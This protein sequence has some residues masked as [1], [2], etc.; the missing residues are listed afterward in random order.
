MAVTWQGDSARNA[1][2]WILG[3]SRCGSAQNEHC[4][5]HSAKGFGAEWHELASQDPF[6]SRLGFGTECLR[7][8]GRIQKMTIFVPLAP[9]TT[10][11]A[12]NA[13]QLNFLEADNQFRT[14]APTPASM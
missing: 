9:N 7:H 11:V 14:I 3:E 12:R 1:T 13:L 6:A 4:G 5:C 2:N 8:V 10:L